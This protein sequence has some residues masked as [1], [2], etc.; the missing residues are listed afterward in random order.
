ME[1]TGARPSEGFP[2]ARHELLLLFPACGDDFPAFGSF[3]PRA[4]YPFISN[5]IYFVSN[6]IY[7]II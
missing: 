7:S 1:F 2:I 4:S 3:T 6:D 5:D